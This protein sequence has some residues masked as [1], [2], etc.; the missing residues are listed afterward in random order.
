M[1]CAPDEDGL[2]SLRAPATLLSWLPGRLCTTG[3]AP[4]FRNPT[5]AVIIMAGI[6][7][8]DQLIGLDHRCGGHYIH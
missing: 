5:Y 3:K 6:A 2:R 7:A 1:C 4:P 8:G